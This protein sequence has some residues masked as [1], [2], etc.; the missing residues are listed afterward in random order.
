MPV[1]P[2]VPKEVCEHPPNL[3]FH[4]NEVNLYR[5][6]LSDL[7]Y[8]GLFANLN[9]IERQKFQE[10]LALSKSAPSCIKE[11]ALARLKP[12]EVSSSLFMVLYFFS[13]ILMMC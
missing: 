6:R 5:G 2:V 4:L 3:R 8:L 12:W 11:R 1:T 9:L 10:G 7:S 13:S